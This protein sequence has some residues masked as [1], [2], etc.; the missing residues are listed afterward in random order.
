MTEIR[1]SVCISLEHIMYIILEYLEYKE[2][3][4]LNHYT[5]IHLTVN[6]ND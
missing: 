6:K 5:W 4:M 2:L 1:W 3:L